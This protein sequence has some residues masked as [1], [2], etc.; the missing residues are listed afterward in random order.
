MSHFIDSSPIWVQSAL[1]CF[2]RSP[3]A[4]PTTRLE[5]DSGLAVQA[6]QRQQNGRDGT[7][8]LGQTGPR[9]GRFYETEV[10]RNVTPA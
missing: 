1:V 10:F 3:S 4:A 8:A 5:V 2:K 7:T 9:R 6:G